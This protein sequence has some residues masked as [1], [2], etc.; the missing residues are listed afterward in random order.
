M[1]RSPLETLQLWLQENAQQAFLIPMNDRFQNEYLPE[2]EK[3]IQWLTGFSGSAGSLL[4]TPDAC[5]LSVDSR[6]TEQAHQQIDTAKIEIGSLEKRELYQCIS[7]KYP[8]GVSLCFDP[9]L[10]SIQDC[11]FLEKQLAPLNI[12]LDPLKK[13]PVEGLW[14]NR[15]LPKKSPAIALDQNITGL[16]SLEKAK[17][18]TPVFQKTAAKKAFIGDVTASNWLLNIRGNDLPHTP[19]LFNYTFLNSNGTL[20]V[21]THLTQVSLEIRTSLKDHVLFHD[22]KDFEAYI[23]SSESL[24]LP[25]EHTPY[26]LLQVCHKKKIFPDLGNDFYSLP[27]SQKNPVEAQGIQECH[28]LDG[29]A[30]T[31]FLYQLTRPEVCSSLTERSAA[32]LL[33]SY[34]TQSTKY[35]T[36]SFPTIS[37]IGPHAALPHYMATKTSDVPFT[38][39]SV[40]LVDSGGQYTTGTTDITRTVYLGE[41]PSERLKTHFTLVLKGHIAL[42]SAHFPQGI[43]GI[44]LDALAR[45]YLWKNGLDYGHGTGHGVGFRPNVHEAPPSISP[46]ASSQPLLE[47]MVLS[48]EPAYYKPGKYGIRI[49]NLMLT[50]SSDK[51]KGFLAFKTLSLAPIDHLL[52]NTELLTPEEKDWLNTY[53]KRVFEAH[54]AFMSSEERVWLEQATAPIQ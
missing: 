17:Q 39:E 33:N 54:V 23:E 31:K 14:K 36:P 27:K 13:N 7:K 30:V 12:T 15:P 50:C 44:S 43:S 48:N 46:R 41:N 26:E 8:Q 24:Y 16:S 22:W 38:P 37:A 40:Y 20:D 49:E 2:H 11:Q 21:F 9:W 5:L 47:G 45:Q 19:V 25:I 35:L 32:D 28:L 4:I 53:H 42:A 18:L 52:I 6:Y 3:Y 34:R 51:Q 29:L 1:E 10:H